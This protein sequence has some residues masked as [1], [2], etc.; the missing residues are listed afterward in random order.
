MAVIFPK[1]LVPPVIKA[2]FPFKDMLF[3]AIRLID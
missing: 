3:I 2:V 1:F